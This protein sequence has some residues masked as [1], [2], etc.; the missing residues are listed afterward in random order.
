MPAAKN[1]LAEKEFRHR[2]ANQLKKIRTDKGVGQIELATGAGISQPTI[3]LIETG[4]YDVTLEQVINIA[5]AL[6]CSVDT[7]LGR[8]IADTSLR[9]RL[10]GAFEKL[11]L[12]RQ[13]MLVE[14]LDLMAEKGSEG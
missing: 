9:G 2:L 13:T 1:K 5:D 7:L 6:G 10:L 12:P 14:L 8:S 11:D 4:I 3:S